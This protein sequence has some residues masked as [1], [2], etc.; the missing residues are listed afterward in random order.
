MVPVDYRFFKNKRNKNALFPE[1]ASKISF[2]GLSFMLPDVLPFHC[3]P[4]ALILPAEFITLSFIHSSMALQPIV[5][6]WP[7]LQ[8]RN[9]FYIDGGAPW[10][11]DQP[12]A[13]PQPTHRTT[14]TQINVHT[15]IHAVSVIQTHDPS[16]RANGESPCLRQRGHLIGLPAYH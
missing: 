9:L 6:P 1:R 5:G 15:D 10:T 14:Q 16:V 8:F 4:N 7:L 13:R 2:C 11:S 12:V 3:S